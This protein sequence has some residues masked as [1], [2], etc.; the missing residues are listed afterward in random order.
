MPP[1]RRLPFVAGFVRPTRDEQAAACGLEDVEE[2][3]REYQRV[4]GLTRDLPDPTHELDWLHRKLEDREGFSEWL[5]AWKRRYS[6]R[7]GKVV[8]I[9]PVGTLPGELVAGLVEYTGLYYPGV[10][11]RL[12]DALHIT[13]EGKRRSIS[14]ERVGRRSAS[15]VLRVELDW[16]SCHRAD[17]GTLT[18]EYLERGQYRVRGLLDVLYARKPRD[19]FCI[20]GVT[21]EDLYE[22]NGD[23]FAVG[24]AS[25]GTG[26]GIFSFAR[27][28]PAHPSNAPNTPS[29]TATR[30][31]TRTNT[32]PTAL[33]TASMSSTALRTT[34]TNVFTT[35]L[36]RSCKVLVHELGHLYGLGHCVWYECCMNGS[37]HLSEDYR[38]PHHLC[39]VCLRKLQH[40]TQC[41]LVERYTALLGFYERHGFDECAGWT[42]RMLRH[43]GGE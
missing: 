8:Y 23:S 37:G 20:L 18:A 34:R 11:V 6:R 12:M 17:V 32:R 41:S 36:A 1:R 5:K 13:V 38:Q 29:A 24:I 30:T 14:V 7:E 35:L 39:P 9:Q 4:E 22:S 28:D 21:L 33:P 27:Y 31:T 42:G 25:A 40:V 19:A 10:E 2:V 3:P 26:D 16:R 15:R 43:L